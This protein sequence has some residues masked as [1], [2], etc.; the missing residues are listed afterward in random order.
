MDL[1]SITP[2]PA[3]LRALSHPTRLRML[4]LLRIDGPAT[5]TTLAGRLG[6]NTGATSYHLRQLAQ[7]GFIEEDETRGNARDR[8]WRASHQST[9]TNPAEATTPEEQDTV[10]GFLQAVAIIYTNQLQQSL[11]ERPLLPKEW[12]EASTM[13]DWNVRL[14][15]AG[16]RA[17]KRRLA[18]VMAEVE[19]VDRDTEGAEAFT[20]NINAYV[21]PGTFR[22]RTT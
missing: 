13:S 3:G 1:S 16:A 15:A 9:Q 21:Q 8:W 20:V 6:L 14:T 22:S 7:H 12:D 10:D 4:A 11:E 19:E 17:L 5:A 18:A 2:G